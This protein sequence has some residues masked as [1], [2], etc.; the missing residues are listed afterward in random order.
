[1][2]KGLSSLMIAC[3]LFPQK[4]NM[5]YDMLMQQLSQYVTVTNEDR[6][7]II[8]YFQP[9]SFDKYSTITKVGAIEEYQ[10][11][12]TE[13]YAR[14][15][16]QLNGIELTT[17]IGWQNQFIFSA[18]SFVNRKPSLET[19]ET[20]AKFSALRIHFDDL[21]KLY[22]L[23]DKWIYSWLHIMESALIN[24][25]DRIKRLTLLSAKERYE[26]LVSENP[27]L[28]QDIALRYLA[29]YIGIKPESLSRI[30]S[31]INKRASIHNS[32]KASLMGTA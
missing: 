24:Q 8:R 27:A 28:L 11:F 22:E 23:N 16:Y 17:Q 15:F 4:V 2:Q 25:N 20:I 12:I 6:N 9:V 19:L 32:G 26:L 30:R 29:S 13:G 7:T 1:M 14:T 18:Q 5:M 3:T 31:N 10:Y 21:Q